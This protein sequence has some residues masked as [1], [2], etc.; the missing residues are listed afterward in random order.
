LKAKKRRQARF[1]YALRFP[2][3]A[4]RSISCFV[5]FFVENLLSAN[6]MEEEKENAKFPP[7]LVL[8]WRLIEV[9]QK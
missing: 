7:S 8:P 3:L 1:G 4:K 5:F 6:T 9:E 2:E